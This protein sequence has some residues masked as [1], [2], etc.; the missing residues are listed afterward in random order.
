MN[1]RATVF[2][3]YVRLAVPA[4]ILTGIIFGL[5]QYTTASPLAPAPDIGP[6]EVTIDPTISTLTIDDAR[7]RILGLWRSTSDEKTIHDFRADG[8][9][10]SASTWIL[11]SNDTDSP[12]RVPLEEGTVYL[13]INAETATEEFAKI[14]AVTDTALDI[15]YLSDGRAEHFTRAE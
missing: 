14:V 10:N 13:G 12:I 7:A 8:T 3:M 4:L 6:T 11:F 2:Y 9:L 15:I 1:A 5:Y